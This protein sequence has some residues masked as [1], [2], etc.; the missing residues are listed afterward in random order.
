MK[1]KTKID[2]QGYNTRMQT[3]QNQTKSSK[4]ALS[5]TIGKIGK[6]NYESS[7][8]KTKGSEAL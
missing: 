5:L 4:E 3:I 1:I 2:N 8:V 7:A 6:K